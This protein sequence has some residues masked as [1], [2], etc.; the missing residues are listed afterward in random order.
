MAEAIFPMHKTQELPDAVRTANEYYLN[1][2][3]ILKQHLVVSHG[4]LDPKNVLWD[5]DNNPILIDLGIG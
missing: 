1:A 2:I 5:V 3:P 4:D